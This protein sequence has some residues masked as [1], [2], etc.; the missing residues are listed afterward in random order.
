MRYFYFIIF[1][2]HYLVS[3]F[4]YINR[5]DTVHQFVAKSI[6]WGATQPAWAMTLKTPNEM[7]RKKMIKL[8]EIRSAIFLRNAS[9]SR[10]YG[11]GI[12]KLHSGNYAFNDYIKAD[13]LD[14]LAVTMFCFIFFF[15]I[16]F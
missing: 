15:I 7:D 13:A 16:Y 5:I 2:L 1:C 10:N 8:F 14:H 4:R 6:K 3:E 9:F 11:L 12:E